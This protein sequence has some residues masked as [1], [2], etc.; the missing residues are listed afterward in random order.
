M[1]Y[2]TK[3]AINRAV[4]YLIAHDN[5]CRDYPPMLRDYICCQHETGGPDM[6]EPDRIRRGDG[7]A[8]ETK[9][10]RIRKRNSQAAITSA[11]RKWYWGNISTHLVGQIKTEDYMDRRDKLI[12]SLLVLHKQQI[13]N[14]PNPF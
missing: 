5:H 8:T 6:Q 9:V 11:R 4:C 3:K 1:L 14:D 7:P 2:Q 12:Y 13:G 10:I